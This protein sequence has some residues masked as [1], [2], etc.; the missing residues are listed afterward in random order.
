MLQIIEKLLSEVENF[1]AENKEQVEEFRLK[2]LSKKGEL[3]KI[4]DEFRMVPNEQKK[5]IGQKINF[6]KQTAQAKFEAL[7][8]NTASTE[9]DSLGNIDITLPGNPVELGSHHPISIV[10]N[11]IID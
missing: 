11:E 7:Q 5:E 4:F 8:K 10:R 9:N 6:L 2:Y 3:S 1:K